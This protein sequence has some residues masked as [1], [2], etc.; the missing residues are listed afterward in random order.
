MWDLSSPVRDQ[1]PCSGN[2]EALATGPTREVPAQV[3]FAFSFS[4]SPMVKL[5][6][7]FSVIDLLI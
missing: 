5:G 3:Y 4:P 2:L 7:H 6:P 1:I